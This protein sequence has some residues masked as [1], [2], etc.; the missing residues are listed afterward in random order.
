MTDETAL[1]DAPEGN[2]GS[3]VSIEGNAMVAA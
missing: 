2:P 1:L 3:R